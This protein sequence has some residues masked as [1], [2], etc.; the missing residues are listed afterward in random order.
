MLQLSYKST[1]TNSQM[2]KIHLNEINEKNYDG[3]NL[4]FKYLPGV[5]WLN[6]I[7]NPTDKISQ[8]YH[9]PP[10]WETVTY[11]RSKVNTRDLIHVLCLKLI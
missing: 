10:I 1:V 11:R 2:P 3:Y 9:M 4:C 6:L 8:I 7:G 5:A